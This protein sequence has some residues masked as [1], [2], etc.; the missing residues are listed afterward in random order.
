MKKFFSLMV[1]CVAMFA[2]A[3]CENG[4]DD[5]N[6]GGTSNGGDKTALAK[7]VLTIDEAQ[8]TSSS[9]VVTWDAVENAAS[10]M[11]NNGSE[12]KTITETSFKMENLNAGTY[13]VKVMAMAAADSNY[14]NSEFATITYTATGVTIDQVDWVKHAATLPTEEDAKYGYY[15][16]VHIFDTY[17]GTGIKSIKNGCF[18]A[19]AYGN[20]PVADLVKECDTLPAA[21][22]NEA[23]GED[24]IT[25]IFTLEDQNGQV[26]G[27]GRTFRI[28]SEIT[29]EDGVVVITDETIKTGE[30]TVHPMAEKWSGN[31][32]VKTTQK[33][34]GGTEEVEENGE[35]YTYVTLTLSEGEIVKNVTVEA[36]PEYAWNA[37]TIYGLCDSDDYLF[38]GG[39]GQMPTFALIGAYNSIQLMSYM[40]VAYANDAGSAY[41]MWM[42]IANTTTY[43]ITSVGGEYPAYTIGFNAS[44]EGVINYDSAITT[45]R[46]AGILN[47]EAQT[48]FE[49]IGYIVMIYDM[50]DQVN[51]PAIYFAEDFED[52]ENMPVY[53]AGDMT[54]T[55]V[56]DEP[57]PAALSTSA[58]KAKNVKGTAA[59]HSLVVAM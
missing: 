13:T 43:G 37:V 14:S 45:D 47:D 46:Y 50:S 36:N 35:T 11:V 7:P 16:F 59:K 39:E 48:E 57:A 18:D 31:W 55:R 3:A 32:E 23:N 19:E 25:L 41:Y 58:P 4:T 6:N 12:N 21:Y 26:I 56:A 54:W 44:E 15:P 49:T 38:E 20:T 30:G 17:M 10:Y 51:G 33:L 40:P 5:T 27:N 28:V 34:L 8:S 24:G 22:V 9:F 53:A 42:G 52:P 29:N 1:A 2:F